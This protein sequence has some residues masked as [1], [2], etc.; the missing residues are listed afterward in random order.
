VSCLYIL[1]DLTLTLIKW[2]LFPVNRCIYLLWSSYLNGLSDRC[3]SRYCVKVFFISPL[4][5]GCELKI[6]HGRHETRAGASLSL[7]SFQYLLRFAPLNLLNP[8]HLLLVLPLVLILFLLQYGIPLVYN[9]PRPQQVKLRIF[10]YWLLF[11]RF[12]PRFRFG[13]LRVC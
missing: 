8:S 2:S 4:G 13:L 9:L 7:L 11:L 1:A 12:R 6:A 5:M 10:D 3:A